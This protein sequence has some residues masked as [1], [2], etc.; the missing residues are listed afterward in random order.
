MSFIPRLFLASVPAP[1]QK[2]I[3][4]DE[5]ASRYLVKVLR[6]TAG[7]R[8]LG[9]DAKAVEYELTLHRTDPVQATAS[10][11]SRREKGPAAPGVFIALAQSLPKGPKIDLVLRQGTEAGVNRF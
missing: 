2:E 1:E 7:A 4:L 10:I 6:L 3:T 8:F 11:L 9:F 5:S